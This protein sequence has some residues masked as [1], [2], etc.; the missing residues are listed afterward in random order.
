MAFRYQNRRAALNNSEQYVKLFESR[1]V[2]FVRQ[3]TTP[4]IRYPSVKEV[5]TLTRVP[6]IWRQG[7]RFFKLSKEFY[8]NP[9]YWW[10]IAF[11][12]KIPLESDIAFGDIV[13][14][15]LPLSRVL[16]IYDV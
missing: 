13:Y 5:M 12:N 1:G 9:K 6:H 2:K 4:R 8:D 14:I 15:P 10:V 3:Y 16:E 7:D 11:Y